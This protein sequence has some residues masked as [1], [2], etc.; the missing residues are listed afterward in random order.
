MTA[1]SQFV[2]GARPAAFF[3]CLLGL[4]AIAGGCAPHQPP[5]LADRLVRGNTSGERAIPKTS[6][7]LPTAEVVSVP[8]AEALAALS[9]GETADR[10]RA[11]AIEYQRLHVLDKAEQFASKAIA[12]APRNADL[13]EL[14]A[15][16][17]RDSDAPEL[18]LSDAHR[19]AY[20]AP[21]SAAVMNTLGTVHFALDQRPEAMAAFRKALSLDPGAAWAST[22]LCYVALVTGDESEALL[23]CGDA[24]AANPS[25]PAARNNLALIHAAA[26]R[27]E[28]ARREFLK[29]GPAPGNYNMG[30][31]FLARREYSLALDAFEAALRAEPGFDAA[32]KRAQEARALVSQAASRGKQP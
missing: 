18:A 14:R 27:L 1:R 8:L 5:S 7:D 32:F 25:Q 2:R 13:Y 15:R 12:A 20:L 30:I 28:D 10:L 26:G 22:N 21:S 23:R 19:A 17:W 29:A 24:L 31:V 6:A 11:V 9:Q 4:A 3:G 16:L